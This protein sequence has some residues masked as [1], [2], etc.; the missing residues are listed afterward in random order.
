MAPAM[1]V[2]GLLS[3]FRSGVFSW[4]QVGGEAPPVLVTLAL[5]WLSGTVA[6]PV[7]WPWLPGGSASFKGT[8]AGGLGLLVWPLACGGLH[9]KPWDVGMAVLLIPALASALTL[10]LTRGPSCQGPEAGETRERRVAVPLQA[11]CL[12]AA[13]GLWLA[14]RIL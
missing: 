4:A 7:A 13:L 8:M 9:V 6:A 5:G 11:G 1:L 3:G 12:A 14:A 10:G 2:M